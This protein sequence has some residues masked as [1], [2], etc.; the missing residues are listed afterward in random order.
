MK[1]IL[2]SL[3]MVFAFCVAF[4][5]GTGDVVRAVFVD[6]HNAKWF[7]T[8]NGLLRFDGSEWQAYYVKTEEPGIVFDIN[9]SNIDNTSKLLIGTN[10]G[11][12]FAD[13]S[14][15]EIDAAINDNYIVANQHIRAKRG[16]LVINDTVLRLDTVFNIYAGEADIWYYSLDNGMVIMDRE[17]PVFLA[18]GFPGPDAGIPRSTTQSIKKSN[19][20]LYLGT[21][22][23]GVGRLVEGTYTL[24]YYENDVLV[25]TDE[26]I[27]GYTGASYYEPPYIPL[28]SKDVRSVLIDNNGYH[29]FGTDEGMAFH[30]NIVANSKMGWDSL[31]TSTNGLPGNAVNALFQ[32]SN[33]DIWIA[34]DDGASKYSYESG[35]FTNLTTVDGLADNKVFDIA[36]DDDGV[37]W[38]ATASGVSGYDGEN[39]T[40]YTT[41]DKAQNFIQVVTS[42]K[43]VFG[44]PSNALIDI[45]PN[46]ATNKVYIQFMKD[47][48]AFMNVD[49]YDM[50]GKKIRSLFTGY[51]GGG[52]LKVRWDLND[53]NGTKVP[54]GIYFISLS[55]DN[56]R[57]TR[58]IVVL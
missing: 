41:S 12:T 52:D 24:G 49:V 31:F 27:D 37:I 5:Q 53:R 22:D 47:Q 13:Y 16:V 7:G 34:T 20:T 3:L 40:S 15:D 29:W 26:E 11:L 1:R 45:Y 56:E 10:S 33:G 19:D 42:S 25:E 44:K 32:D 28:V 35:E 39:L 21:Q 36:E 55:K 4:S 46:P 48:D 30:R 57:Y 58:K 43:P 9:A 2:L 54:G 38:F 17:E 23:D 6:E 8:D 51:A 50:S 18:G 14:Q